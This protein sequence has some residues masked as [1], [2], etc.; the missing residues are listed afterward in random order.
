MYLCPIPFSQDNSAKSSSTKDKIVCT[1][2]FNFKLMSLEGGAAE[3]HLDIHHQVFS[4]KGALSI[5]L[6]TPR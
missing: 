2:S 1:K 4:I 5:E 3:S 6:A